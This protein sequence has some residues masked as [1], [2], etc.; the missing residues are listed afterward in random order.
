[1]ALS[2]AFTATQLADPSAIILT[3]TSSGSDGAIADRKINIYD[4]SNNIFGSSPYDWPIANA[5]TTINPLQKDKALL[6]LVTWVNN[7]GT[8]LYTLGQIFVFTGYAE[9]FFYSLTQEQQANP[10]IIND[11]QYF[12]NKSKLRTLIDSAT[13]AISVG[14][15]LYSAQNCLDLYQ[16]MLNTPLSYF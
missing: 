9:A 11:Q 3:D 4:I 12:S 16:P 6:I 1:M 14:Q 7:V 15:D 2:P 5:S 13:Q 8:V 10:N